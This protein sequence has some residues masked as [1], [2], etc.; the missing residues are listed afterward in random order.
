MANLKREGYH[1]EPESTEFVDSQTTLS[2]PI[3]VHLKDALRVWCEEHDNV[4]MAAIV[5]Q[6]IIDFLGYDRDTAPVIARRKKYN[7]NEERKKVYAEKAR[8]QRKLEKRLKQAY[9]DQKA[10]EEKLKSIKALENSLRRN[11]IDPNT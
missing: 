6:A 4:P 2:I 11:G 9:E 10:K 8:A 1:Q 5:R 7:S 3:T